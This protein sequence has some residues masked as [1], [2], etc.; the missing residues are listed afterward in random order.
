MSVEEVAKTELPFSCYA[1]L[2]VSSLAYYLTL[3]IETN[4][5]SETSVY[6]QQTACRYIPEYKTILEHFFV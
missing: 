2:T 6:F 1:L 5:L 4:M 3:K